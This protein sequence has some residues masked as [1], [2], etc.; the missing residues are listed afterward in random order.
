MYSWDPSGRH[1]NEQ[2][3]AHNQTSLQELSGENQDPTSGN[4]FSELQG[5]PAVHRLS[6][7]PAGATEPRELESPEVTPKPTQTEFAPNRARQP[8]QSLGLTVEEAAGRRQG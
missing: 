1:P 4:R 2:Q 3:W 6:E 8:R 5:Q 7:L